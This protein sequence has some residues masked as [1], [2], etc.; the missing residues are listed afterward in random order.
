MTW[1]DG[2]GF[3]YFGVR[4]LLLVDGLA[5]MISAALLLYLLGSRLKKKPLDTAELPAVSS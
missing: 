5:S 3:K 4:G 2:Q 1:A